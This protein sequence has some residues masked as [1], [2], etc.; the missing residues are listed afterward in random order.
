[1]AKSGNSM[2]TMKMAIQKYAD[3][4]VSAAPDTGPDVDG[5]HLTYAQAIQTG[6]ILPYNQYCK[7]YAEGVRYGAQQFIKPYGTQMDGHLGDIPAFI[8]TY[9]SAQQTGK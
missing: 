5:L 7:T 3:S 2:G 6:R 1:M 8:R 9:A 4:I